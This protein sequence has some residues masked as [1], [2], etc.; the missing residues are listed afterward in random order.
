MKLV[1]G[2]TLWTKINDVLNQYPYL[3]EDT[4][5]DVIIIGAGVT[6]ALCAYTFAKENIN[7]VLID[8][9]IIGYGSTRGC[10]A[11]LEYAID[12]NLH[13]L[14]AM[15]GQENAVTCFKETANGLYAIEKIVQDLDDDCA[16]KIK[17]CLYY[18]YKDQDI[19]TIKN[20]YELRKNNG[21]QVSYMDAESAKD[22]FSFALVGGIYSHKLCG[23]IDPYRF[24]HALIRKGVSCGLKVYE[25]TDALEITSTNDGMTIKTANDFTI[26][27]KKVIMAKGYELR[28]YFDKKT[29]LL[30]RSFNIVTKPITN[31]EGW[32][33]QC[34]IRDMD[35]PYIYVRGTADGRIIMGGEDESLGG[36]RSKMSNLTQDDPLSVQ[37]YQVLLDKLKKLFPKIPNLEIDYA[38]SGYFGE[39]KDGLPYIGEHHDYPNHYFCMAYGSNGVING[40]LGSHMILDLYRGKSSKLHELFSL[41][42]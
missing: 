27:A 19:N 3:T 1:T 24:T 4:Q 28:K 38:F 37:K 17:D 16:F 25:N 36:E 20:E 2:D 10:T 6:G 23:E 34:V 41:E 14:T 13:E 18:T 31:P 8:K 21:F 7:T 12:T 11:I 35:D 32:Y 29:A 30:T 9:S 40:V 26:K 33:Q 39:T 42:R 5:C 22:K 15:I